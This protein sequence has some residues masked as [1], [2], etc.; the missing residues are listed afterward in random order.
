MKNWLFLFLL[1]IGS[2]GA[3]ARQNELPVLGAQVFIEPG[4]TPAGIDSLFRILRDHG[5]TV[6]RIRMFETHMHRGDRWDFSLYDD[7]FRSAGKYGIRLFATLFPATDE[8]TDLGGFKFPRSKAHLQEIDAYITAVVTHFRQFDALRTWV[9]QNEP[10]TGG[11]HVAMTDLAQTVYG[12]WPGARTEELR[13]DGYLKADFQQEEFLAYYTTWYLRRIA[14]TVERLDPGRCRHVNPHQIL[15]TLPEYDFRAYRT[16]LTSIGLSL[17]LSWHFGLFEEREYP[18]GVSLMCD[19]IR[20]NAAD[21][22]F[23]V[24]ELQG[25]NVTAS[26]RTP[27]CPTASHTAQYLWTSIG[28]GA[29]G[30]IFWTLNPRASVM[31]AGEWG[32]LDFRG[33]PSDRLREAARVADALKRQKKVFRT[34]EPVTAPVTLLYNTA[35][36]RIQRRNA[37]TLHPREEGRQSTAVMKSLIAAYEA[38][39]AWGVT[40]GVSDMAVFDWEDAEGHIAV[41]PD[42]VSLPSE[43]WPR[44]ESF[45]RAGGKLIVTGLSGFYDEN[46]RCLFMNG[47]PLA[48]CFG[49][50]VNEFKVAGRY[51][52]LGGALPAHLW[53]G[54]LTP[55][56]ARPELTDGGEVVATRNPFGRGEVLWI[57]SPVELGAYHRDMAPLIRFYGQEC[58]R[59]IADSPA[60]FS[61]PE[62]D[63]S[64]RTMQNRDRLA[65]VIVNKRSEP[66]TVS[67]R[68]KNY[69]EPQAIYGTAAPAG[70]TLTLEA[71]G[72]AVVLW[73]R[74][75]SSFLPEKASDTD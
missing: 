3:H 57:P 65:T 62:P 45:V 26:G 39:A 16:F 63:V 47:F 44:I 36:L 22:P 35:S 7:A 66:A 69:S 60:A 28:A 53:K 73:K 21:R 71:D 54:T 58:R 14:R 17:H 61:R 37:D 43:Y 5:M 50:E 72:C 31:E 30:V 64:M 13:P 15:E 12:E 1:L 25:G 4:Q 33:Q 19:L 70:T 68:L 48:A 41:I 42:M 18:L 38:F 40:P 24:T 2:A 56:T 55:G 46:M 27:Y 75:D 67:L 74:N 32:L 20:S 52:L 49:A 29:E 6:A 59:A 51:F 9:L 8:R 11:T 10:G 34:L 23:W